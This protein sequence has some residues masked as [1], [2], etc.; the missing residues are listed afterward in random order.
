MHIDLRHLVDAQHLI[1]VEVG[2][3]DLTVLERNGAVECGAQPK[4][5]AA[6]H[7]PGDHVRIARRAAIDCANDAVDLD[8]AVRCDRDFGDLRDIG[9]KCFGDRNAAAIA[10]G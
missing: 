3:L 4:A 5:D 8:V 1:A 7:L 6:F 9:A 2:L 10:F